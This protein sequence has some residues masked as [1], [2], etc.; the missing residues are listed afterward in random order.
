MHSVI[1]DKNVDTLLTVFKSDATTVITSNNDATGNEPLAHG[2]SRVCWVNTTGTPTDFNYVK[3]EPGSNPSTASAVSLR[4][5]ETTL[6]CPWFFIAGDYNAFSLIKNTSDTSLSGVRVTWYGLNGALAATTT[7]TIPGN[8]TAIINA[9]DFVNPATFSN[10][11]VV[12][13]HPGSPQQITASTTTLS[14][15]TGLGFDALFVQRSQW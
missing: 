15:T 10:G 7:V 2:F 3:I 4:F 9:R 5:V 8:G 6:F 11:S 14:G 12:I 1:P 13:A